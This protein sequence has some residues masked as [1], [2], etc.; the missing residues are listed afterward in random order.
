MLR[1][2]FLLRGVVALMF[3]GMARLMV[4][5]VVFVVFMA[6]MA[7]MAFEFIVAAMLVTMPLLGV[8]VFVFNMLYL[9]LAFVMRTACSGQNEGEENAPSVIYS[10]RPAEP[11]ILVVYHFELRAASLGKTSVPTTDSSVAR[12]L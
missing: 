2:G 6:F 1:S 10:W 8:V 12:A 3:F 9:G 5:M 11:R 4:I 7:F